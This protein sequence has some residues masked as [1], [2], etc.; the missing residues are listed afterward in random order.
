MEN[1]K[2]N[3]SQELSVQELAIISGGIAQGEPYPTEPYP[4][5]YPIDDLYNKLSEEIAKHLENTKPPYWEDKTPS[6]DP[7]F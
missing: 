3:E 4:S 5:E 6:T 2:Q 1:E 7:Y